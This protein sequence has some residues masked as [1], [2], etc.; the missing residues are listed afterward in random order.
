M[1]FQVR[2]TRQPTPFPK[3]IRER[4]NHFRNQA[5][6]KGHVSNNHSVGEHV[7]PHHP[8]I[9]ADEIEAKRHGHVSGSLYSPLFLGVL[10]FYSCFVLIV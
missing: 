7:D 5:I 8:Y 1:F 9:P 6:A 2:L 3:E 10:L 4:I